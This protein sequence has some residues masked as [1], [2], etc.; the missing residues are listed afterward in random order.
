MNDSRNPTL[1]VP[2]QGQRLD[3]S[4][5]SPPPVKPPAQALNLQ[6]VSP[7]ADLALPPPTYGRLKM[8]A[9]CSA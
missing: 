5:S 6:P 3:S 2:R 8:T 7:A 9:I 1:R 4:R